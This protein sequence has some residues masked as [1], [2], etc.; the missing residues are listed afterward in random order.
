MFGA[1]GLKVEILWEKPP[2]ETGL[3]AGDIRERMAQGEAWETMMPAAVA[4][5][6]RA[7]GIPKRLRELYHS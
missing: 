3:C 7:W 1:A 2:G 6:M 4:R 5:R